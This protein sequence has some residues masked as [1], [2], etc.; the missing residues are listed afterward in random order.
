MEYYDFIDFFRS[1]IHAEAEYSSIPYRDAFLSSVLEMLSDGE[2]ISDFIPLHFEGVGKQNR[3]I[4]IDGY[5]VDDVDSTLT[6]FVLYPLSN[7]SDHILT[8]T[9][10]SKYFDRALAFIKDVDYLLKTIEESSPAFGFAS[11]LSRQ[12]VNYSK[13]RLILIT[14]Q[15]RTKN[16][17]VIGDSSL[18][19]ISV[20]YQIWDTDRLHMLA[21]SDSARE[22]IEIDLTEYMDYGIPCISAVNSEEFEAYLCSVTGLLLAEIFNKYGSRLLEGNVRS[23]LQTKGKVNK[24]IR[25]T[26]LNEP[27]KFFVYNNG[28]AATANEVESNVI[29]GVTYITKLKDLQIVN[30]GQTTASLGV[31]LL[32]DTRE[33]SREKIASINVPMKL[34]VV[35]NEKSAELIP[36]ISRYANTQNKVSDSDLASNH[37]FHIRMEEASRRI[38]TPNLDG[39]VQYGTKWYYERANGQYKQETYKAKESDR[40][41][42]ELINPKRQLFKK[43]DLAKFVNL[44]HQNPQIVSQGNQK[45][46][47]KFSEWMSKEWDRNDL[48]FNDDYFKKVIS[49]AILTQETDRIVR[50]QTW[51]QGSY[52]AN[53]VAYTVSKLFRIIEKEYSDYSFDFKSVWQKQAVSESWKKQIAIIAKTMYDHLIK[54]EREVE[55]VTEWAKRQECWNQASQIRVSFT[56]EVEK[57]LVYLNQVKQAEKDAMKEE[58]LKNDISASVAV[59]EYGSDNWKFALA[60]GQERNLLNPKDTQFLNVAIAFEK[61]IPSDKQCKV[62]LEVLEMLRLEGFPK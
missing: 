35:S 43:V 59:Y 6:L 52:K 58:R 22:D 42:F 39:T 44:Y 11:D 21:E 18:N 48:Q 53:V 8:S 45:S 31:A 46:F 15:R 19:G 9:E 29:N 41:K 51:Y 7:F 47:L 4:Q 16:L 32:N 28:I 13:I 1:R 55:N 38:I 20:E 5:S 26:I 57:E 49:L 23:F 40:K 30:G 54:D 36:M 3:K 37:S 12:L 25:V 17:S 14:D 61:R 50:G 33:N 27:H 56:Q 60:W 2:I 10:I 62:I 24:G 34:T